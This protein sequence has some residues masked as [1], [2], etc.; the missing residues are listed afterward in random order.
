MANLIT[1]GT[2]GLGGF[3]PGEFARPARQKQHVGLGQLV[4]AVGPGHFLDDY[5]A[6]FPVDA[7]HAIQ[8]KDQVALDRNEL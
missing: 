2:E 4:F 6:G 8:E 7:A 1:G 5:A 3:L